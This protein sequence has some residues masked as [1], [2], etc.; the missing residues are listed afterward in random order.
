MSTLIGF[1]AW[2]P[3]PEFVQ[4][5]ISVPYDIINTA[6]ARGSCSRQAK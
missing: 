2:R 3:K 1:K 6:E 5:V 4:E